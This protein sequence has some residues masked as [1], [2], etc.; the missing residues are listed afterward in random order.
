MVDFTKRLGK[1]AATKPIDPIEIY[2]TLDRTSDKGPLRQA[3][4]AVLKSGMISDATSATR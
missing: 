1:K 4:A 2:E 3:Q